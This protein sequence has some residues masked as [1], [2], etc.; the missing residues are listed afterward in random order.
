[1]QNVQKMGWLLVGVLLLSG[2]CNLLTPLIFIGEH[3]KQIAAEFDKLPNSRVA[4]VVWM[5]QSTLFDWPFARFELATYVADKLES[6]I[7]QR[8]SQIDIVDPRDV[9]DFIQRANDP[10]LDPITIGR[11]YDVDYVLYV[12]I[13]EYQTRDS[14]QP[15]L[16]RGRIHASV[17][18][19]DIRT[20]DDFGE[21]Y[22]MAAVQCVHPE[23]APVL[24]NATNTRRV[25]EATHLKFSELVAR[26]FYEYE[27]DL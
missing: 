16:L 25:R 9:D 18:V 4:V 21:T 27:E 14:Q 23:N 22:E 13:L 11:E 7:R 6:E 5:D 2:G 17:A 24:M 12:E 15:Q 26:K 3:K 8:G 1:M 20:D 10:V 19:V